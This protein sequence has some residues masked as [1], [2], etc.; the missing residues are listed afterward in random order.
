MSVP[1][2]ETVLLITRNGMGDAEP[3]LQ[4]KLITTYFKLLD[5]NNQLPGVICFYANGVH[6][7]VTGSPV[8][9]SFKSLE[10]KGVHIVLCSTCLNYYNLADQVQVG[11]VGGMTDIIEAQRRAGKVIT[12]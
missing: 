8:L 3:A 1:D 10:A 4:Q 12:L 7:V 11:I 2:S 6:L 5:E 9:D